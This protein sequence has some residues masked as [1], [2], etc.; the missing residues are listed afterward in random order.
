MIRF[1]CDSYDEKRSPESTGFYQCSKKAD[2]F[3]L[4]H[5]RP[6]AFCWGHSFANQHL[7][8]NV[9]RISYGEYIVWQIME[10]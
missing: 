7:P 5:G 6:R 8:M 4:E 3:Y 2:F 9:E 10:S 1:P